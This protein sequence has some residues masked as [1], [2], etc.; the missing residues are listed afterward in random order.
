MRSDYDW[1][2]LTEVE[3]NRRLTFVPLRFSELSSFDAV[4]VWVKN[5]PW[6]IVLIWSLHR[7]P[8][9]DQWA[10]NWLARM[11]DTHTFM[12][13]TWAPGLTLTHDKFPT[14]L[15]NKCVM[16]C[17]AHINLLTSEHLNQFLL[18]KEIF[19]AWSLTIKNT[20]VDWATRGRGA[21][22]TYS[23]IRT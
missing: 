6:L 15:N 22:E 9:V 8:S 19:T 13:Q 4:R 14:G 16:W 7:S 2:I 12:R 18:H 21:Q 5:E 3:A 23:S 10:E 1:F 11:E 17:S 20:P